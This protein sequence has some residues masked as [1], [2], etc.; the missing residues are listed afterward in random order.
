MGN[1]SAGLQGLPSAKSQ[2]TDQALKSIVSAS[3]RPSPIKSRGVTIASTSCPKHKCTGLPHLMVPGCSLGE[4]ILG[5]PFRALKSAIAW[6]LC[7]ATAESATRKL[8]TPYFVAFRPHPSLPLPV[9]GN[10]ALPPLGKIYLIV[11]GGRDPM[12]HNHFLPK[13]LFICS[14]P[15]DLHDPKE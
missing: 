10:E 12:L 8:R 4:R 15:L 5:R 14:S 3:L 9:L 11:S 2:W 6:N 13:L 1:S 7:S